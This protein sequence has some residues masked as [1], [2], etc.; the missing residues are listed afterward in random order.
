MDLVLAMGDDLV[1]G[2]WVLSHLGNSDHRLLEFTIQCKVAKACSKAAA[3]DFRKVDFNELRG[4]VREA[5]RSQRG[6]EPGVQEEW[7]LLKEMIL[8]DQRKVIPTQIKGSSRVQK[9]P[10]DTKSIRECLLAKREAYTQWNGEGHH[11]GKNVHF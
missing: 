2:L 5:L 7:S 11:Q 1:R 3:L 6:G 8:Q 10:W 9:P 4:I